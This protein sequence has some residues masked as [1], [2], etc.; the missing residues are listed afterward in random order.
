[1]RP[2]YITATLSQMPATTPRSWLI[3]DHGRVHLLGQSFHQVD[4]LRLDGDI[5]RRGRLVGDQHPRIARERDRDHHP[6]AH[7]ARKLVRIVV[8]PG[9]GHRDADG[10]EELDGPL[11][12][13]L[14]VEIQVFGNDFLKLAGRW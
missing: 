5:Q 2:A 10:V 12:D 11:A 1:M 8:E 13:T 6:L 4:D 3:Q 9:F 7:A 14:T